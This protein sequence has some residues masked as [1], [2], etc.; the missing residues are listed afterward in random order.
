MESKKDL[1]RMKKYDNISLYTSVEN[2][3]FSHQLRI[4]Y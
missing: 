4:Y 1:N 2:G 3:I